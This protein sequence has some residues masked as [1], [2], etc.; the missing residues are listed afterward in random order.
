MYIRDRKDIMG[1]FSCS[2]YTTVTW[3][4]GSL[5][6]CDDSQPEIHSFVASSN[7]LLFNGSGAGLD[8][9]PIAL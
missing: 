1:V 5:L 3:G 9:D 2:Y 8:L 6:R 4:G 7:N